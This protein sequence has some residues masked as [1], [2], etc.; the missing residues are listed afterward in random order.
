MRNFK[1]ESF[2]AQYLSPQVMRDLK[3]FAVLDDDRRRKLEVTAIHDD[4][5]YRHV[6]KALA[7]HYNLGSN[8]P[9]IQV[10]SVNR[11]GDRSLT[12]RHTQHRRRPLHAN[13][14]E[15]LRH[16]AR[17]WGFTVRLETIDGEG[18]TIKTHECEPTAR[19][20]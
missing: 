17:L 13:A 4:N 19:P 16:V 20:Q 7:E 15:V 3:L 14:E 6:R 18:R 12:L 5:G 8:E 11:E 10:F 2:I 1:D 9:D